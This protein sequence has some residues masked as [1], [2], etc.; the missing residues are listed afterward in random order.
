MGEFFNEI[1]TMEQLNKQYSSDLNQSLKTIQDNFEK[2]FWETGNKEKALS[3]IKDKYEDGILFQN[4][5]IKLSIELIYIWENGVLHLA[6]KFHL[7]TDKKINL[8]RWDE[9][10]S[11]YHKTDIYDFSSTVKVKL[12]QLDLEKIIAQRDKIARDYT[13]FLSNGYLVSYHGDMVVKLVVERKLLSKYPIKDIYGHLVID[14]KKN[15]NYIS[16]E[17][18]ID[19]YIY[20]FEIGEENT[21]N[22]MHLF[23]NNDLSSIVVKFENTSFSIANEIYQNM[24]QKIDT[25]IEIIKLRSQVNTVIHD[26]KSNLFNLF[27]SSNHNNK[28]DYLDKY[29]KILHIFQKMRNKGESLESDYIIPFVQDVMDDFQNN[30]KLDTDIDNYL[31]YINWN[32]IKAIIK[33]YNYK[34][35]KLLYQDDN[36]EEIK[37]IAN[38]YSRIIM[39]NLGVYSSSK[40]EV[41]SLVFLKITEYCNQTSIWKISKDY[42]SAFSIIWWWDYFYSALITKFIDFDTGFGKELKID[43][44]NL[45]KYDLFSQN[46]WDKDNISYFSSN[47][48][49]PYITQKILDDSSHWDLESFQ[50]LTL[51]DILDRYDMNYNFID[52]IKDYIQSKGIE[53]ESLYQSLLERIIRNDMEILSS[54]QMPKLTKYNVEFNIDNPNIRNYTRTL[55][56]DLVKNTIVFLV[57]NNP[58]ILEEKQYEFVDFLEL[59]WYDERNSF[60]EYIKYQAKIESRD[61]FWYIIRKL[62]SNWMEKDKSNIERD[63]YFEKYAY[64]LDKENEENFVKEL[65]LPFINDKIEKN[66]NILDNLESGTLE[67]IVLS[68]DIKEE[69][70][71][72]YIKFELNKNIKFEA[73]K[74]LIW[75]MSKDLI[76]KDKKNL[77]KAISVDFWKYEIFFAIDDFALWIQDKFIENILIPNLKYDLIENLHILGRDKNLTLVKLLRELGYKNFTFVSFIE[78]NISLQ[79]QEEYLNSLWKIIAKKVMYDCRNSNI[80]KR[81]QIVKKYRNLGSILSDETKKRFVDNSLAETLSK[82]VSRDID[83][84]EER[85]IKDLDYL[86]KDYIVYNLYMEEEHIRKY[87]DKLYNKFSSIQ[88]KD[89]Q[90]FHKTMLKSIREGI[91]IDLLEAIRDYKK[92]K[93]VEPSEI[94]DCIDELENNYN[95]VFK[96]EENKLTLAYNKVFERGQ[97]TEENLKSLIEEY[98]KYL[99][100]YFVKD[101]LSDDDKKI[102]KKMMYVVTI[103][104]FETGNFDF[105]E[106]MDFAKDNDRYGGKYSYIYDFLV[107]IE[108]I[109]NSGMREDIN[110]II[111][112]INIYRKTFYS[113]SHNYSA[114]IEKFIKWQEY[115]TIELKDKKNYNKSILYDII[116]ILF[117]YKLNDLYSNITRKNIID[118][119]GASIGKTEIIELINILSTT[120]D[121]NQIQYF[122]TK[123]KEVVGNSNIKFLPKNS[124]LYICCKYAI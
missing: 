102:L 9:F 85:K 54:W 82:Q 19:R 37:R 39:N 113:I 42:I 60:V 112:M 30:R 36:L 15:Y 55:F 20:K 86:I 50:S 66:S 109:K 115:L 67:E 120:I 45:S 98:K 11:S 43:S 64:I 13:L 32:N 53:L 5:M 68:C 92:Y 25:L 70:F 3:Y 91:K 4:D 40:E 59:L 88:K 111:L 74:S 76:E 81:I 46:I 56:I 63:I 87:I 79:K 80:K 58:S 71:F 1:I 14:L 61:A 119:Y 83:R 16:E 121:Y 57:E 75:V 84:I 41:Y 27:W 2:A 103:Y 73:I 44:I 105:E 107:N 10:A 90:K 35:E 95:S 106:I 23:L 110:Y 69:K 7:N 33:Y 104:Y 93:G 21:Q 118:E 28:L 29:K 8:D 52:Y 6:I 12:N 89:L 31:W 94:E 18:K 114:K 108:N 65:L 72:E 22:Y 124:P 97:F 26:T 99:D 38:I 96:K 116:E 122:R 77:E 101:N 17:K 49:V 24:K 100:K 47:V 48:F 123:L 62:Y 117:L 51:D 78:K 34:L